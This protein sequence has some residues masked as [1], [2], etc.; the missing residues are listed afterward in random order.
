MQFVELL[1]D[2]QGVT[3]KELAKRTNRVPCNVQRHF[4]QGNCK[5]SIIREMCEALG[6]NLRLKI[7]TGNKLIDNQVENITIDNKPILIQKKN[8]GYIKEQ[9]RIINL[10]YKQIAEK[11]G[12]TPATVA[13]WFTVDDCY[14]SLLENMCLAYGWSLGKDLTKNSQ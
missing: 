6:Y 10:S 8:L 13:H 3:K 9:L 12:I 14:I 1:L 5:I 11:M 4:D 2:E 7:N